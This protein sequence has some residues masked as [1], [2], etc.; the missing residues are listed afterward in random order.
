DGRRRRRHL[1]LRR[2][3]LLRLHRRP[4]T[5]PAHRRHGR[6]PHRPRLL[7]RRRRRRHLL[8]RR[9]RVP[10]LHRPIVGLAASPTGAGYWFV[11]SDGGIFNFGDAPF[12]GSA[13]G[14]PLP[15]GVVVMAAPGGAGGAGTESGEGPSSPAR[16]TTTTA[17]A[18]EV[19]PPAPG[20]PFQIGLIGDT[21][22]TQPQDGVL[23]A[24]IAQMNAAPPAF[25]V[26]DGDIKDPTTACTD[27]RFEA[28]K[29]QFNNSV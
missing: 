12:L 27:E 13:G 5:Q 8:L 20:R 28:V 18:G 22:Y 9:R 16:P 19:G 10:R 25:V 15:A 7:V 2:R 26:H 14:T 29:A 3:R 1:L 17:P 23:D 6:H 11:A 4:Q 24:V 21:G